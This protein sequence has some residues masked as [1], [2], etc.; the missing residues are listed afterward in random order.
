MES[1]NPVEWHSRVLRAWQLALLR[2]AVT[3]DHADRLKVMAVA[4]AIDRGGHSYEEQANFT[5]FRKISADLCT[6]I[7]R[8]NDAADANLRQYLERIEDARLKRAFASAVGIEI[9]TAPRR[10][11]K[12]K[13]NN[14]LWRGLAPRNNAALPAA[15]RRTA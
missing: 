14:W 2:F 7:L 15:G 3:Q 12:P 5:F 8:Q 10:V 4:A 6:A 9:D 13:A 11:R 1:Q